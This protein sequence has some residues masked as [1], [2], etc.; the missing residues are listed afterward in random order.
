MQIKQQRFKWVKRHGGITPI[1][2]LE[3]KIILKQWVSSFRM[4]QP[5][6]A[7]GRFH[8]GVKVV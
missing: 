4:K 5:S 3:I 2:Q 1:F 8:I 7:E 6:Q